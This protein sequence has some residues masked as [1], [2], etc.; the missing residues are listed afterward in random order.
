M[1]MHICLHYVHACTSTYELRTAEILISKEIL[2]LNYDPHNTQSLLLKYF[3]FIREE[4]RKYTLQIL[5]IYTI[6][7]DALLNIFF[8]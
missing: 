1:Y 3:V 7:C 4:K 2:V 5:Q 8:T 6:N